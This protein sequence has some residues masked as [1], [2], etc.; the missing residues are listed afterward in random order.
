MAF[1]G[2][3]SGNCIMSSIAKLRFEEKIIAGAKII[4]KEGDYIVQFTGSGATWKGESLVLS[5]ARQPYEARLFKSIDGAMSAIEQIGLK[6]AVIHIE[7]PQ[8]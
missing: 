3:G 2:I 6:S 4:K 1:S 5:S 8:T 7:P